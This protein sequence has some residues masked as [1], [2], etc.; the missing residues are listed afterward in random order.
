MSG[1]RTQTVRYGVDAL[2][3]ILTADTVVVSF[4]NC[5]GPSVSCAPLGLP[6]A[7]TRHL[8]PVCACLGAVGPTNGALLGDMTTIVC[9]RLQAPR[10]AC[11]ETPAGSRVHWLAYG[12]AP[13]SPPATRLWP[14]CSTRGA[15]SKF[16]AFPVRNVAVGTLSRH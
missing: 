4:A 5:A 8:P 6:R 13:V 11:R 9:M 10:A 15:H 12:V 16:P 14:R 1:T 2:C 7:G 3:R